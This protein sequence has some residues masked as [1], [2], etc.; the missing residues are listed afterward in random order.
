MEGT[1][2]LQLNPENYKRTNK[3]EMGS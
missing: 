1:Y 3:N 2:I